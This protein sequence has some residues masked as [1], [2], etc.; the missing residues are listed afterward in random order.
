MLG[1][2]SNEEAADSCPGAQK[3][4]AL[5]LNTLSLLGQ[6]KTVFQT[7]N[8]RD[9]FADIKQQINHLKESVDRVARLWTEIAPVCFNVHRV[10]LWLESL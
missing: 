4:A 9:G 2:P 6:K 5:V 8:D 7:N 10:R 1:P 3:S